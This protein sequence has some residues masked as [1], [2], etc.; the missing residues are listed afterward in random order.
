MRRV[1]LKVGFLRFHQLRNTNSFES[2][3]VSFGN[4]FVSK[5][6]QLETKSFE[7]PTIEN[8]ND[9]SNHFT[10]CKSLNGFLDAFFFSTFFC[11]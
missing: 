4:H 11:N 5:L 1:A 2:L 6:N 8:T 10:I 3:K 9:D 7:K